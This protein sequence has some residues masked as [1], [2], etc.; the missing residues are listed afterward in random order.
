MRYDFTKLERAIN[1][2]GLTIAIVA[3]RAG[4]HT[5]TVRRALK[6]NTAQAGV[7]LALVKALRLRMADI[8][9]PATRKAA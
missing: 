9:P 2:R 7:A 1:E 5:S 3:S 6:R 4:V 8:L